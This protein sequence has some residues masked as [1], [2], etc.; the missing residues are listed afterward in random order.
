MEAFPLDPELFYLAGALRDGSIHYDKASRNYCIVWYSKY[1]EYLQQE[2]GPRVVSIFGKEPVFYE[3]KTGHF[4]MRLAGKKYYEFLK[5]K[6]EFPEQGIGQI[7][8]GVPEVLRNA[9]AEQKHSYIKGMFDAEGDVSRVNRYV[10]VSQKNIAILEWMISELN[11]IGI[12]T[13]SVVI[14]DKKTNTC[15]FVIAQK[16]SIAAF[17]SKIGF[18]HPIKKRLLEEFVQGY[19]IHA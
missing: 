17:A 18:N 13:G 2:I 8:W 9:A 3:Y 16:A 14:A 6:F 19:V 4:R 5:M 10:E 7:E 12:Q 1:P 15:K 11:S